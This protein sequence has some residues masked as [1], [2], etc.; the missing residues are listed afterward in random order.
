MKKKLTRMLGV[1]LTLVLL[2]SLMVAA[3][4]VSASGLSWGAEKGPANVAFL[5]TLGSIGTDVVDI[6]ANGDV[7]YAA[8]NNTTY[9]LY[10]STD[11][12]VSW[13]SLAT[14]T[15][16]PTSVSIKAVAVS[17]DDADAVAIATSGNEV[18]YSA[19][20]GSSW[21]DLN[22]PGT[23]FIIQDLDISPG[24]TKHV[25]AAGDNGTSAKMYKIK[26]AMAQSWTEEVATPSTSGFSSSMSTI[27]AVKFSPNYATDKIITA[28]SVNSTNASFEVFWDENDGWNAEV[29][30]FET[31]YPVEFASALTTAPLAA[32]IDLPATYLGM[33]EAERS[34]FVSMASATTAQGGVWRLT[35]TVTNKYDR[36]DDGEPG[37]ISSISYND[38]SGKLIGGDYADNK[39]Y[40]WLT[41]MS[42]ASPNAQ[43]PRSLKQP[44]GA[45][46]TEVA[47]AGDTAVAA[48][49]GDENAIAISTDDGLS[50]N[51]VGLIDTQLSIL[52]D[53]AI[54][55]DGATIYMTS[56]NGT[57]G[58]VWLKATRWS[59]VLSLASVSGTL[60][61]RVAPDD[62][63]VV[64]V[65]EQGTTNVW[66]SK[67]S[68]EGNW[69]SVPCYKV[70][71]VQDLVV[72]SADI[73]YV[74]DDAAGQGVSKTSNAG[75][76]WGTT[77]EPKEGISGYMLA[78]APNGDILVGGSDG[79]V[80][81]SQD[82]GAT[83][84]R[85]KSAGTVASGYGVHV[86]ADK[87]YADNNIIYAG[88]ATAV[89]RGKADTTTA[90][91]TRGALSVTGSNI[92][93]TGIVQYEGVVYAVASSSNNTYSE[94]WKAQNLQSAATT[95]L[96]VWSSDS[97]SGELYSASPR[98]LKVSSGPKLWAIDSISPN[99][100]SFTD[101]VGT[102]GPTLTSPTA[103]S[104]IS[105]NPGT[106]LPYNVNFTFQRVSDTDISTA[107]LQIAIDADFEG[108]IGDIDITGIDSD[109]NVVVAGPTAAGANLVQL[110]PGE[111]Y[112]WR[113]RTTTPVLSPWTVGD[114]FTVNA[115]VEEAAVAEVS[116]AS[117]VLGATDVSITPSFVWSEYEGAIGYEVV[118]SEDPTFTIIDWAHS[119]DNPWYRATED[120]A[121]AYFTTYHWKARGI[122]V[123]GFEVGKK[124]TPAVGGDWATGIF[125]TEEEELEAEPAVVTIT[126]EPKVITVETTVTKVIPQAIPDFLLWMIIGIGAVLVIALIVLIVRTRRVT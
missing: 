81:F 100:E 32:D 54:S 69:K 83:Y 5:N 57:A 103:D 80:A 119:T 38:S 18:E 36:W 114:S 35:D 15:S 79:Y 30:G 68:G 92:E 98:A 122:T 14:S 118:V 109:T 77:K 99:L 51:D 58:S 96:A 75:F 78:L 39:V 70:T 56:T 120:E 7:V 104:V 85:T 34:A 33:D 65:A 76:T 11:G 60:L 1:G 105:V 124:A 37:A 66:V 8:T 10:K 27:R 93:V 95:A 50:F 116:I 63:S 28:V 16:F 115:I 89:K 13:I 41:P 67:D 108:I 59:R 62:P 74:L 52:D 3:I 47:W 29:T 21:T 112:Y 106:G 31:G 94:L 72:D 43:R 126:P 46:K 6:A 113:V 111:T 86:V 90:F 91:A 45:D 125:T 87:D 84:E 102:T 73:A 19:N 64:Y 88:V 53:F 48:T 121:L 71:G 40:S 20:G 26:L 117:P 123:A 107:T 23:S 101:S 82:S 97:P 17:V 22:A 2:S 110:M 24:A 61:V 12:G 4:P 42:G 25:A 49:S 44:G 55:A 9:P